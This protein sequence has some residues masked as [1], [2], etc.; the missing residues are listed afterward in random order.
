MIWLSSHGSETFS[1][2]FKGGFIRISCYSMVPP[3]VDYENSHV[4]VCH[5]DNDRKS[6]VGRQQPL[7]LNATHYCADSFISCGH[8]K[9]RGSINFQHCLY[10]LYLFLWHYFSFTHLCAGVCGAILCIYTCLY[11][12]WFK[13][14]TYRAGCEQAAC[15]VRPRFHSMPRPELGMVVKPTTGPWFILVGRV[16]AASFKPCLQRTSTIFVTILS[17]A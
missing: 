1:W 2:V 4:P 12:Q 15:G 10:I 6:S 5:T 16:A 11:L 3:S 13:K 7:H 8:T 17:V 14:Y 9:L